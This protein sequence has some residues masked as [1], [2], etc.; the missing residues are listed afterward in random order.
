LA[1]NSRTVNASW[2]GALSWCKIQAPGQSLGLLRRT[3]S[4]NLANI[5][6]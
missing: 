1:K 2:A 3:A 5:S 6:I 4:R